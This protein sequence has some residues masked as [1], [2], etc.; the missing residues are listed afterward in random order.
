MKTTKR[1]GVSIL[2]SI[3]SSLALTGSALAA[4]SS[5]DAAAAG[6][7][8]TGGIM[9]FAFI[10]CYALMILGSIALAI[11]YLFM[12]YDGA[13]REKAQYPN[14]NKSTWILLFIFFSY[15]TAIFYYFMVKRKVPRI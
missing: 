4:S 13:M 5:D 12:L 8:A 14:G 3:A 11:F 6:A 9:S 10:C 15:W 1:I 2:V 7:L